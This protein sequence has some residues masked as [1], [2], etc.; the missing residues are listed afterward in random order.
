MRPSSAPWPPLQRG[1]RTPTAPCQQARDERELSGR[2]FVSSS[3]P[4]TPRGFGFQKRGEPCDICQDTP[5]EWS[6]VTVHIGFWV[7]SDMS[8]FLP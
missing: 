3:W 4:L 5:E 1:L 6:V 2:G 7:L 8:L